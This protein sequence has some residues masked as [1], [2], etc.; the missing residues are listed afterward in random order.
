M[1]ILFVYPDFPETFWSFKYALPFV[2][3]K[4]TF[5]PLG[6]LV[7]ANMLPEK[8]DKKLIDLNVNKLK[9]RDIKSAD[10]V[11]ISAMSAQ[12]SSV[13]EI[14][15]RCKAMNVKTV[16]GGPLF[17]ALHQE[18][19]DVDHL[20][21]N[22]AELTLPQFL[23]DIERGETKHIY[24]SDKWADVTK[25]VPPMWELINMKKY[26]SLNL[27]FSRGCPYNCEFCDIVLLYGRNPRLKKSDQIILELESIYKLG[28]RGSI[29]FV[30]DNFIGKKDVIKD[31]VLPR[32][33]KW[34]EAKKYPFTFFTEASINLSDDEELMNLMVKAGFNKVFIGIESPNEESLSECNKYQNVDRNIL[35]SIEKC[36]HSGL[37][38][39]GGFIL[40]FDNDPLSIFDT[41]ANFIQKSNIV[42][43]MVGLLNAPTGTRLYKRLK[44]EGRILSKMSGNNTDFTMN[45]VPKMNFNKLLDGY[46]STLKSIY[47]PKYYYKRVTEF[48]RAYSFEKTKTKFR[49]DNSGIKALFKSM[50]RL[51]IFG[52]ERFY[53]W[54]L[55]F[56]TL[57]NRPRLFPLAI[58]L[59]INGFH[60]RKIYKI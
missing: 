15:K 36:L 13:F 5:P 54:K 7:V 48:L 30:D 34:Q 3:K 29:F 46:K 35:D 43:A 21:L 49:I 4:A 57:V 14:I 26:V 23:H 44:K 60:F 40:G 53:Y 27:Q 2:S 32:I 59:S 37:Q 19:N 51:G 39:Q 1:K 25:T 42:I 8:W 24:R 47:A 10:Y 58:E 52:S 31:D 38:V 56:W 41:L 20:I 9:D 33:I 17:T 18:F 12:K 50:I 16:A 6:L 45:F 28:W 55:F 22:E 11:F